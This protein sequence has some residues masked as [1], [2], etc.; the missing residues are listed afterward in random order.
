MRAMIWKEFRE[1]LKWAALG[2][3]ATAGALAFA[4]T[5][6]KGGLSR[7]YLGMGSPLSNDMFQAATMICSAVVA[8]LLGLVQVLPEKQLDK[9]AFLVHR[10]VSRT[11]LL[12]GKVIT[13]LTLYALAVG[14]PFACAAVWAAAP[15]NVP[16]PF[17]PGLLLPVVA[18]FLAGTVYYFAGMVIALREARWYASRV[19]AAGLAVLCSFVVVLAPEFWHALLAIVVAATVLAIATWGNFISGGN[20]RPQPRPAKAALGIAVLTGIVLLGAVAIS[21]LAQLLPQSQHE[22]EYSNYTVDDQGRI[23]RWT[24]RGQRLVSVTDPA[25]QPIPEYAGVTDL[26]AFYQRLR[27]QLSVALWLGGTEAMVSRL[28]SYRR[29]NDMFFQLN[30][31][32]EHRWYYLHDK[33]YVV[34]YS[35]SNRNLVGYVTPAGFSSA[36]AGPPT[37]VL[38]GSSRRPGCGIR[39]AC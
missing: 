33:R 4:I 14:V 22:F 17:E 32:S 27:G 29:A 28:S 37:Q 19:L 39:T 16:A 31:P 5:Q 30:V 23:I 3:L 21:M 2:F 26:Q 1:N 10:P 9:W 8:L 13:G 18:D 25:G 15:G 12:A 20:Y 35:P 38:R 11:Q 24:Q 36:D 6:H 7:D 34:G